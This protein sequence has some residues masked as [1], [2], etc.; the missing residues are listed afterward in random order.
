MYVVSLKMILNAAISRLNFKIY[1]FFTFGV[2]SSFSIFIF[3]EKKIL[4]NATKMLE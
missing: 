1:I 4:N 3:F 2:K